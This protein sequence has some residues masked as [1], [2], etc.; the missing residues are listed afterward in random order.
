MSC[1][2]YGVSLVQYTTFSP[3][4]MPAGGNRCVLITSAH[5]PCWMEV[6]ENAAPDWAQCPRN[7]EFLAHSDHLT[8]GEGGDAQRIYLALS[9]LARLTR[10]RKRVAGDP[11]RGK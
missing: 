7:P 10:M 4:F 6:S 11:E 9:D 3:I 1:P 8:G 5:S 2:F